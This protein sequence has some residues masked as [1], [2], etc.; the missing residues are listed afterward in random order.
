MALTP[1]EQRILNLLIRR[2]GPAGSILRDL[3]RENAELAAE[4]RRLRGEV[5]ARRTLKRRSPAD[6][7]FRVLG[8]KHGRQTFQPKG[9]PAPITRPNL[10]IH[11]HLDDPSEGAPYWDITSKRLIAALTPLLSMLKETGAYVHITKDGDGVGSVYS[12]DVEPTQPSQ[13]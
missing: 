13:V 12:L 1:A 2:A 8:W 11:T 4:N 7:R 6:W 10:R 9:S 5:E 3:L